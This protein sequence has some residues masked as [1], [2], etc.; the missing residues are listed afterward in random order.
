MPSGRANAIWSPPGDHDGGPNSLPVSSAMKQA[1][2]GGVV[3][4]PTS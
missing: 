2:V 4:V 3:R 1:P